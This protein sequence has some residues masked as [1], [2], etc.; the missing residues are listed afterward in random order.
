MFG[1]PEDATHYY[2]MLFGIPSVKYARTVQRDDSATVK[3]LG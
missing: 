2:A 3:R 1:I